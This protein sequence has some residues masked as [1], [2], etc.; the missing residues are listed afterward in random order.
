MKALSTNTGQTSQTNQTSQTSESRQT[1]ETSQTSQTTETSPELAWRVLRDPH[2]AS[3][4]RRLSALDP[5]ADIT[6]I[7]RRSP[8]RAPYLLPY[9]RPSARIQ[10][11]LEQ[12]IGFSRAVWGLSASFFAAI[13]PPIR[14]AD[15]DPAFRRLADYLGFDGDTKLEDLCRWHAERLPDPEA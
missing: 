12:E 14:L 7:R 11:P 1:D 6:T 9:V 4:Y 3:A 13:T 2:Y 8:R 10:L 5:S 15:A